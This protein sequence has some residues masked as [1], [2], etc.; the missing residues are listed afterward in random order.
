MN[1]TPIIKTLL[2]VNIAVFIIDELSGNILSAIGGLYYYKNPLFHLWQIIT[3]MFLHGGLAHLFFNMLALWM[4]GRVMEQTWGANKLL[5]YYMI[6]GIGAGLTQEAGQEIGL[7]E[8]Y[9]M[10]IG[11]SGAVYGLLLAFGMTYPEEKL[12]VIPIPI[13]IKAKY[14]VGFYALIE[15]L[16]CM[17]MRDG[18]AHAAHLGGMIFGAVLILMWRRQTNN[19]RS[20]HSDWTS[21]H[22]YSNYD[23]GENGLF[24]RL[25]NSLRGKKEQTKSTI[26]YNKREVDYEY[27]E[28]KRRN[29]DEIDRILDKVRNG[30]YSSLTEEEKRTLFDASKR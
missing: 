21:S 6:C 18:V 12:F 16:D 13:P 30:G 29:S 15:L 17:T 10:T 11:A 9:A 2:I 22:S 4:F 25:A 26:T 19:R 28:R 23:K 7:I 20:S 14:F 1:I 5:I 8:P 27:N 3:Y 24:S